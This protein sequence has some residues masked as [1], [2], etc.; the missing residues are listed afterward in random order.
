VIRAA[1]ARLLEN[2]SGLRKRTAEVRS[3]HDLRSKSVSTKV[4]VAELRVLESACGARRV[5]LSAGGPFSLP[6]A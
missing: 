5:T 6:L 1:F 3:E 2:K 4:S